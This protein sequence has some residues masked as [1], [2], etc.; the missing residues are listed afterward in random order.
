[1]QA[2]SIGVTVYLTE[3]VD[4][5]V[6]FIILPILHVHEQMAQYC[7]ATSIYGCS[8]ASQSQKTHLYY[9]KCVNNKYNVII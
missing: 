8:L 3:I 2:S 5:C 4:F 9:L 1:M 7:T 6:A